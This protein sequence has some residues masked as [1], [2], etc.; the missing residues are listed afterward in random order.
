MKK[1]FNRWVIFLAL[2]IAALFTIILLVYIFVS[3][4]AVRNNSSP[5]AVAM[6]LIPASTSTPSFIPQTATPLPSTPEATQTLLPGTFAIGAYVQI[7]AD[8]LRIRSAPGLN[9]QLL[10]IGNFSEVFLIM[11]GSQEADGYTWWQLTAPYDQTRSGWA[12]Q[13][14]LEVIPAP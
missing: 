1:Y 8:G 4:P 14:Y 12:V 6:T 2:A 3:R 9:G 5:A 13:D 10:F 11:G 7:T